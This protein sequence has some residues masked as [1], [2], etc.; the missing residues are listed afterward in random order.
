VE[1]SPGIDTYG[2]PDQAHYSKEYKVTENTDIGYHLL[3]TIV[4]M[5]TYQYQSREI[6]SQGQQIIE[7]KFLP[8][9]VCRSC[10]N[11]TKNTKT[12][13]QAQ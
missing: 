11:R 8:G 3:K 2:N 10:N 12:N 6:D 1:K 4:K 13:D 9:N 5:I 7:R